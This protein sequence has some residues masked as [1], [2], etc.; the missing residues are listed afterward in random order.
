MLSLFIYNF[1]LY[2][3]FYSAERHVDYFE[4]NGVIF[5][6]LDPAGTISIT[7]RSDVTALESDETIVLDILVVAII[8]GT[9]AAEFAASLPNVFFQRK[10]VLSIQDSTGKVSYNYEYN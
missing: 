3:S 6:P 5:V 10:T 2:L 7:F 9:R 8:P 1:I 4:D